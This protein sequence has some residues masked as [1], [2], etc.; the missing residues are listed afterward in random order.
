MTIGI[1]TLR[2]HIPGNAS[3]KGKRTVV[4]SLKDR[5]HNTFNI[6]VAEVGHHDHWTL[7]DLGIAMVGSDSKFVQSALA[8]AVSFVRSNPNVELV[9]EHLELL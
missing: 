5:L 8:K 2:L 9:E 7:C 1:V 4:K 3:L 6:S